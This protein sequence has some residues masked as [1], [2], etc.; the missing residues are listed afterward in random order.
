MRSAKEPLGGGFD[1]TGGAFCGVDERLLIVA[2]VDV[3]G[4]LGRGLGAVGTVGLM[5][6]VV[7]AVVLAGAGG[8]GFAGGANCSSA[9]RFVPA[10]I[11][12]RSGARSRGTSVGLRARGL[13]LETDTGGV[14][15]VEVGG[16]GDGLPV[17]MDERT[18]SRN[19]HQVNRA[20]KQR[21]GRG[22]YTHFVA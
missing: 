11:G 1:D 5:V 10:A 15:K 16:I 9:F 22:S 8:T 3:E 7:V 4:A 18:E 6:V 14:G 13:A 2:V 19:C 12:L 21:E 17:S 20:I